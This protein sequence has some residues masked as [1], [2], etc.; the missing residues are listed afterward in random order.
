MAVRV[1]FAP[2]PT[3]ALHIGGLRTALFNHLHAIANQ[4]KFI[5]RIEDTDQSRTVPGAADNLI[6]TLGRF[7]IVSHENIE[8]QSKRKAKYLSEVNKL[9]DNGGAYPCF[10]TPERLLSMRQTNKNSMYD[11]FCRSV[12]A[13]EA[14]RRREEGEPHTIRLRVPG[15][16]EMPVVDVFD[17]LR[18]KISF[19]TTSI[20][21]QI[22][23]KSDGMPTYHLASVVDDYSMQISHVIRGEEW[24]PST[25]KHVLLYKMFDWK[26]PK[27]TH[28]PLLLNPDGSK[29]SKR[30]SDVAVTD[31]LNKGYLPSALLNFVALLGWS[32]AGTDLQELLLNDD[33]EEHKVIF[34]YP[35][36]I[37][38]FN[39]K[40][41]N[42]SGAVVDID[43]LNWINS[44]HIRMML[45]DDDK[46]H[47][48]VELVLPL[49]EASGIEVK[50]EKKESTLLFLRT[51]ASRVHTLNDFVRLAGHFFSLDVN[52]E[53]PTAKKMKDDVW[54]D[55]AWD[56]VQ[57]TSRHIELIKETEWSTKAVKKALRQ[58]CKEA[59]VKK[60]QSKLMMPIRWLLTGLPVGAGLPETIYALG[61]ERTLHRIQRE[62]N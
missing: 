19:P 36:L 53:S 33:E 3:G 39:L 34:T 54:H 6:E 51:V 52:L 61:K 29:L 8:F 16:E 30:Q 35:E 44:M 31:Y 24:L 21:D 20:D 9:V 10:C 32:P 50:K 12:S 43:R 38:E 1:R 14:Q 40:N 41:V 55:K 56:M 26:I 58:S 25:P 11:K 47:E 42:K 59:G 37:K 13:T 46:A 4:G 2:S 7:G 17:T 62:P 57:T 5:I 27:F 60:Q 22:L 48:V 45:D 28:L 15:V 23:L 49:L 18:G